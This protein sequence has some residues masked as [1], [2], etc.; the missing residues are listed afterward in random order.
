M[1]RAVYIKPFIKRPKQ[2]F[3]P[4]AYAFAKEW[5]EKKRKKKNRA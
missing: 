3:S 2:K 5:V 1:M 4:A